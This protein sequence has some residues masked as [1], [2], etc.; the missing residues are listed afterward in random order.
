MLLPFTIGD[1]GFLIPVCK[2]K[3]ELHHVILLTH[4][5]NGNGATSSL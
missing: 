2:H 1:F 5:Q 4:N 3:T